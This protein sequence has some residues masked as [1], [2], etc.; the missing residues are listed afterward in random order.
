MQGI[1]SR[2]VLWRHGRGF[3]I[4]SPFAYRFITEVLRQGLPFYAY[5]DIPADGRMRLLFRV[6]C[7]LQPRRVEVIT[8][9]PAPVESTLRRVS[10][11]I[12][13]VAEEA[14]FVVADLGDTTVSE[15]L[16]RLAR[17]SKGALLLNIRSEELREIAAGLERGMLFYNC[18]G[19]AVLASLPHLPR[20]DFKVKF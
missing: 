1:L 19:T 12:E 9:T 5:R 8:S 13:F 20:Q 7:H 10:G 17:L 3:G 15:L 18:R 6:A 2:Y 11:K 4:H 14:D 16:P